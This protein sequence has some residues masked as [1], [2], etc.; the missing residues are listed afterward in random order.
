VINPTSLKLPV[1]QSLWIGDRLSDMEKLSIESFLSNGHEF[2]LYTYGRVLNVPDGATIRDASQIVPA[3]RI[4]KY[5][6]HDSYAGFSNL[7]RYKLLLDNA[8]FWVDLDVVC[9]RPFDFDSDYVYGYGHHHVVAT[10]V[11]KSPKDC[12]VIQYC[13]DVANK[14]DIKTLKWGDTG[15]KLLTAAV[16]KFNLEKFVQP[17]RIFCPIRPKHLHG[18]IN[19]PATRF[20]KHIQIDTYAI[21]LYNE[22][23]RRR[24]M[25]KDK[26]NTGHCFYDK[27]KERY[28]VTTV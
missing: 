20:L 23:W 3:S 9:L 8:G 11:I 5:P 1:I 14:A 6:D 24:K 12:D 27:L 21:H 13:Y 19:A 4:F 16:M 28:G 10:C 26:I 18:L 15:P 17:S 7:F 25:S 2:H 22:I